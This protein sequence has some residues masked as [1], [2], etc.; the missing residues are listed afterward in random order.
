MVYKF[1]TGCS[2]DCAFCNAYRAFKMSG[3]LHL[4]C[5]VCH[6]SIVDL[7]KR[8]M[9]D[10]EHITPQKF[11]EVVRELEYVDLASRHEILDELMELVLIDL[12]YQ[13]GVAISRTFDKWYA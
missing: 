10:C 13:D 3:D 2:N 12:G 5:V 6:R 4:Y 8:S 7:S 1:K 9:P 11:V